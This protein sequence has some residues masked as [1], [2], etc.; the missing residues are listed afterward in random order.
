MHYSMTPERAVLFLANE[1]EESRKIK[2]VQNISYSIII[3]SK[4][5]AK[6]TFR[7][8]AMSFVTVPHI[9]FLVRY[10]HVLLLAI[11]ITVIV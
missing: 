1:I 3:G 11:F 5:I 9:V 4:K 7:M 6:E 2:L 10:K 8:T